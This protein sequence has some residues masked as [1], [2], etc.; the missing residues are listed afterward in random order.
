MFCNIDSRWT[1]PVLDKLDE[2]LVAV[3]RFEVPANRLAMTQELKDCIQV[4][5]YPTDADKT[6]GNDAF[7]DLFS[8]NK[9]VE[10]IPGEREQALTAIEILEENPTN[11]YCMT[12]GVGA[13][14]ID[15]KECHTIY[16][17]I[18]ELNS[19]INQCLLFNT[20]TKKFTPNGAGHPADNAPF[21]KVAS[22]HPE[23]TNMFTQEASNEEGVQYAVLN[24]TDPIAFF[25]IVMDSDW[26]FSVQMNYNFAQ[27]YYIKMS[28]ALFNML[29][30][31]EGASLSKDDIRTDLAGHR[32]MGSRKLKNAANQN[33]YLGMLEQKP[34]YTPV[35]RPIIVF[36]R[37]PYI[38]PNRDT[39]GTRQQ[40]D[41]NGVPVVDSNGDPVMETYNTSGYSY[42]LTHSTL[43]DRLLHR[44]NNTMFTAPVSVA[45]SI[46]RIKSLVFTSSMAT[47]SEAA[48]G[49]TYFRMLTDYTIPVKTS[50]SFDPYTMKGGGV[51]ENA[52]SEYTFTNAN[53]SAGRFLQIT[54]PSPLY[55]LKLEVLA[56][57]YNYETDAF[58]MLPIPLPVG[59][60]FSVKLVFISKNEIHRRERPDSLKA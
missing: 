9:N 54:D 35:G 53:P 37:N 10:E 3:T 42:D 6:G 26:R 32:F 59:G 24:S 60:T 33:L 17:F 29:G 39:T 48:T 5:R 27:K 45:D 47:T 46:N 55:E 1:N 31:Q 58:E 21:T 23:H 50:F 12:S 57:A 20:G 40:T 52:A 41:D 22:N 16:Q 25:K 19:K 2:Y 34:S 44:S 43:T 28:R 38:L 8:D 7:V 11:K 18:T 30:F 4:F 51:N 56:K 14:Q 49:G 13:N 36:D 15:V